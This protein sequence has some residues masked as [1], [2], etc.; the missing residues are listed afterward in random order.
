VKSLEVNFDG[1]VGPTHNYSGL[2]T[3]N[4]ASMQHGNQ[5][6]HPREAALQGLKKMALLRS[7]G[8]GQAVLPP[9]ERPHIGFLKQLGFSGSDAEVL[10]KVAKQAPFLLSAASSA[11][12]MWTA[13]SCTMAPSADTEDGKVH[14]TAA[15]L[16]SKIHRSIEP[17]FTARVLQRIFSTPEYFKHHAPLPA[18]EGLGDEGAANHTRLCPTH[19]GRG[20]HLFVYGKEQKSASTSVPSRFPARQ[21]REA[22]EAVARLHCLPESQIVVAKQSALAIDAGVFHNDVI[23]VGNENLFFFHEDTF[24]DE[25]ATLKE[26]TEK[27]SKLTATPLHLLKIARSEVSLQDIVKSYLFNSQLVTLPN[28]KMAL[29]APDDCSEVPSVRSYLSTLSQRS[30]LISDV[31]LPKLRESMRNGGGPACLRLRVV[32]NG[33]EYP[34]FLSSVVVDEAKQKTLESWVQK[35]YRETLTPKELSDPLL[36]QESRT[37]LDALTQILGLGSIYDFQKAP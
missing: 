23:S 4:V 8:V 2:S 37:A 15:N 30:P 29:I 18:T 22:S 1:L 36:L 32:L 5:T 3:G 28:G 6:S 12:A 24:A 19:S 9:H 16:V 35:H 33:T 14:F 31:H 26:M 10:E 17:T 7:L 20:L 11:S 34:R 13:N 21:T 27:W 25:A